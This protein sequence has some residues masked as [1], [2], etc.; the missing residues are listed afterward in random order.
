MQQARIKYVLKRDADDIRVKRLRCERQHD[1]ELWVKHWLNARRHMIAWANV[2]YETLIQ[3]IVTDRRTQ[4]RGEQ[5]P[6]IP[7]V[8]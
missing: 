4:P 3:D 7:K 2:T 1:L 5:K 8:A 6:P